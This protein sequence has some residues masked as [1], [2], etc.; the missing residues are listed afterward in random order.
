MMMM[1]EPNQSRSQE[2]A[3]A[4][5]LGALRGGDR[6]LP[7]YTTP[8]GVQRTAQY[9]NIAASAISILEPLWLCT[10]TGLLPD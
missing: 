8:F 6:A 2:G 5:T 10:T 7:D 9:R 1:T 3:R 4:A